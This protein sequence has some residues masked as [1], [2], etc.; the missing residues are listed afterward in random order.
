VA[1][2]RRAVNSRTCIFFEFNHPMKE[3]SRMINRRTLT[4]ATLACAASAAALALGT[5][6]AMAQANDY[7]ARQVTIVA[8]LAAGGPADSLIRPIAEKL[9]KVWGKPVVV[10]NRTGAGGMIAT[11]LVSRAEPDG[12]T[13]LLNLTSIVQNLSLYKKAPYD[14][15]DLAPVSQIGRQP[16]SLSV[17]GQSPYTSAQALVSA[18]KA[19]PANF[20][21]GSFGQG[22]TGHI[23]GELFR[24][25]VGVDM[26][27]IPYRGDAQLLPDLMANRVSLA[28]VAASTAQIRREDKSLNI[29]GVTG[30]KRFDSMSDVPTLGELGFKGFELVGWYGLFVPAAT[31][32]QIVQ[33]ISADVGQVLKDP[34]IQERMRKLVIEPVGT[35][36]AEFSKILASDHAKWG[37]LIQRFGI[38]LE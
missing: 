23:F 18:I 30:P 14:L 4:R 13:I 33:K 2:P 10:D 12:Y 11:Q 7:P 27:H 16:M 1:N 28:F 38:Q 15:K 22:S 36:P 37:E 5:S 17:S 9:S 19:N 32:P 26:P 21:F 35:T 31:N 20:N 29:L 24:R 3:T 6:A 8:P 34:E 25:S